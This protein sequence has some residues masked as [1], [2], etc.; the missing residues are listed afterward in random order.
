MSGVAAAK[1]PVH[2]PNRDREIVESAA[3]NVRGMILEID[4]KKVGLT[5]N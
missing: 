3:D 1:F 5:Q 4:R 2:A